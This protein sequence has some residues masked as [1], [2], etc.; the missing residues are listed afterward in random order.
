MNKR[1]ITSILV[2]CLLMSCTFFSQALA[3]N[4]N[5]DSQKDS[6]LEIYLPREVTIKD[7]YLSL[8]QVSIIRGGES[9][10]AKASRIT[11]GRISVPG[12]RI[13]IDRPTVLSRLASNGI[14]KS[15]VTL[16]GAE[17]VMVKQQL[18]NISSDDFITL[19]SN[20]LERNPADASVSRWEPIRRP[21]DFVI[22]GSSKDIKFSHRLVSIAKNQTMVEVAVFSGGKKIGE[23]QVSFGPKYDCRIAVTLVDIPAGTIISPNDIKIEK[24]QSNYP[25]PAGW[26]PPYGLVTR[27]QLPAN[28]A[29]RPHMIGSAKPQIIVKRNQNVVIRIERPGFLIT[30][31]GKAIQDGRAGEYIKIRNVDSQRIIVA[32]VNENGTVEPVF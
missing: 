30:A 1:K 16:K 12:Q 26:K 7:S 25:E 8:G 20:F 5:S 27:R 9:L 31:V 10:V 13:V 24:I 23:R 15:K 3:N 11:L 18:Q 32:K 14:P 17:K 28:T 2:T 22:P 19:A 21:K 4:K 6:T 29:L